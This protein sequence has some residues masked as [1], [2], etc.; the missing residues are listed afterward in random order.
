MKEALHLNVITSLATQRKTGYHRCFMSETFIRK[1]PQLQNSMFGFLL[2]AMLV[3][4]GV[5]Q[6]QTGDV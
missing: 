2:T 1:L 6:A 4:D 5:E 3:F